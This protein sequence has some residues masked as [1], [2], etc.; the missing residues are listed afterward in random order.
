M[1]FSIASLGPCRIDSPFAPLVEARRTTEAYVDEGDRVLFDDTISMVAAR[2]L[3]IEQLPS[4]EPGGPRSRIFFEPAKTRVAIVTCGGLC[5]GLNDVIRGLVLELTEH[6]GVRRIVGIRNGYQGFIARYGRDVVDLTPDAVAGINEHGGT[7]LGTSRGEQ[8]AG[9]IV[10]C[11]ER[12][13]ISALFVVGGDG[14]MRGAI[15]VSAEIADRGLKIAVVGVPK[16]IDNDIPYINQSFGFQTAFGR[17]AESI[18]TAHVE[19]RTVPNGVG[20]VRLMG[21]HS[22]FIA[23]YAA[24]AKNDADF[25]LIP[26][27]PFTLE[28]DRGLLA[29][30]RKRV[31]E[32]GHAVVVV[33]EG[34]GQELLE[35]NGTDASGNRRL[36]DIG[37]HLRHRISQDFDEAGLELNLK[38]IDPSYTIRSVPA[39]PYDSVYCLRLAHTA[40]HAAMA[41]RTEMVVGRWHGRFVHVPMRLAISK[42]NQVDPEGDLWTSVLE[43][44]GQPPN[45]R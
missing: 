19:A 11:L 18:R 8:D 14:T 40:V 13:G 28:G 26:E 22:G 21:R 31:V 3:P 39:N 1:D 35:T 9:E 7:I 30:L 23:C 25:V 12:L 4:F 45:L 44:T 24:L 34:A 33:A 16:T 10:D 42:R 6:Y 38:Y 20:L 32:R 41:G 43:A 29:H 5:P 37:V 17:A 15:N 2:G 36:G 27:V